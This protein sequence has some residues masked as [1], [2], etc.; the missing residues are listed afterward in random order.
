MN[1]RNI[2]YYCIMTVFLLLS[3]VLYLFPI[4][5]KSDIDMAIT[6]ND[7]G[8]IGNNSVVTSP[9]KLR[10]ES[11]DSLS[12]TLLTYRQKYTKGE[13]LI[14]LIDDSNNVIASKE[15]YL[16]DINDNEQIKLYF[17]KITN[18]TNKVFT[19]KLETKDFEKNTKISFWASKQTDSSLYSKLNDKD[20]EKTV[21]YTTRGTIPNKFYFWYPLMLFVLTFI[22]Y[23]L[24]CKGDK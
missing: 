18:V 17:N 7:F 15:V 11:I 2:I 13:V 19:L 6:N 5:D 22:S 21:A 4:C 1:K 14:N 16:K 23:V 8:A 20:V 9:I 3:A 12:F 10:N 24:Y